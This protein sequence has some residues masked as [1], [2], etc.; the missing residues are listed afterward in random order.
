MNIITGKRY[1]IFFIADTH[2]GHKG[3]IT[4]KDNNGN[5]IRP[6]STI[7][8]ADEIMLQKWNETIKPNDKIYHLGDFCI[9]RRMLK[10]GSL[11]NGEKVLIKGNHDIFKINEY[12][13]YFKDVR[14][15]HV[16]NGIILSHIP[17]HADSMMRFGTNIHGH[18]HEKRVM[19]NGEVDPRYLCVSVEHTAYMPIHWDEV[20][21]RII[22]QGGTPNFKINGNN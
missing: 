11:L 4:W 1:D 7:E 20:I 10:I 21:D 13:P 19:L 2:F 14:A 15:Y 6:F 12:L 18:L 3:S 5:V 16:L 9:N 17:I 8:E 22:K